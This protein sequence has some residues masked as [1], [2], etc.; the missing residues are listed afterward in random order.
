MKIEIEVDHLA[1][2][3]EQIKGDLE[4][5]INRLNILDSI[6]EDGYGEQ[7]SVYSE[8]DDIRLESKKKIR[9]I[10]D[11]VE[12]DCLDFKYCNEVL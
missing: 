4:K 8:L 7:D 5:H 9:N 3:Y 11:R 10:L 1:E 6:I 2:N 12:I